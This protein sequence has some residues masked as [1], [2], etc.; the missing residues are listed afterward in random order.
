MQLSYLTQH[1]KITQNSLIFDPFGHKNRLVANY[2]DLGFV[3][4]LVK[5]KYHVLSQEYC[6]LW[7]K[8]DLIVFMNL[9]NLSTTFKEFENMLWSL[10]LFSERHRLQ[11]FIEIPQES[12]VH[13]KITDNY[14]DIIL[15]SV[16]ELS[17]EN[18]ED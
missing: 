3:E 16:S 18:S 11:I 6:A 13:R 4:L 9:Y 2:L 1:Q 7:H 17:V 5:N 14:I 8:F 10:Y 15:N 12:K